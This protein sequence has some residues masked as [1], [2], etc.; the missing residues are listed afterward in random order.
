M[1]TPSTPLVPITVASIYNNAALPL[2]MARCTPD[3]AEAILNVVDDLRSLGHDLRLSDLFRTYDMQRQAN[4]DFVEGR[5]KA[6]SPPPG[7]S[8]HEAGRAMDIDLSSIGVPLSRFWEIAK[9]RG[10]LPIIDAP[11][12]SRSESWRFDCRGSHDE[13]YRYVQQGKAGGSIPPYTQMAHSAILAIGV[14]VD[15]LPDQGVGYLQSA[16]IRLGFDPGR[17]DGVM[18]ERTLGAMRDAGV[19]PDDPLGSLVLRLKEKFPLEF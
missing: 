17:I 18:G 6:Y 9:A 4:L 19:D 15:A 16:L 8:T 11:L 2:R 7:G 3:T 1:P 10:F 5:K 12:P 14:R 13:V